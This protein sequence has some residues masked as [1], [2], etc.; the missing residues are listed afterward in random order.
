MEKVKKILIIDDD[1]TTAFLHKRQLQAMNV[2]QEVEYITDP[3]KAL[4]YI[5][6]GFH[7]PEK[8]SIPDLIFLDL[9][10][11]DLNGFE[12]LDKLE[13]LGISL[14]E[15]VFI[16]MHTASLLLVHKHKAQ[17]LYKSK[18]K[19]FVQKPLQPQIV[20]DAITQIKKSNQKVKGG[21]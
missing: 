4:E 13:S 20:V 1:A 16:V 9:E 15:D 10:M 14:T 8:R 12:F 5:S 3:H 17:T 7:S 6:K 19:G 11:P 2:A 21:L 18:L